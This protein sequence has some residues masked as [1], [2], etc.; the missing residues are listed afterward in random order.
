MCKTLILSLHWQKWVSKILPFI[1]ILID[2]EAQV[3]SK[4]DALDFIKSSE[5]ESKKKSK[6]KKVESRIDID[7]FEDDLPRNSSLSIMMIIFS[8]EINSF[9]SWNDMCRMCQYN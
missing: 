8:I 5:L 9:D 1:L 2:Y 3:I 4:Q 7:P 6:P